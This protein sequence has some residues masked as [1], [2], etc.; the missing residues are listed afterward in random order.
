ML[1]ICSSVF[2]NTMDTYVLPYITIYYLMYTPV[3]PCFATY[4]HVLL[5]CL[6]PYIA[7][8]THPY[9]AICHYVFP[10]IPM[11]CHVYS[12]ITMCH[13][14]LSSIAIYWHMLPCT[15]A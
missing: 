9:V 11:Y 5:S 3:L 4:I 10:F 13:H 14:I 2:N 1:E 12:F 15:P 8:Y 7:M 6:Y